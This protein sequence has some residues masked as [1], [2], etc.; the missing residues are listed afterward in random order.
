LERHPTDDTEDRRDLEECREGNEAAFE[1]LYQRYAAKLNGFAYR[2]LRRK[3]AAE[4]AVQETFIQIYRNAGKYRG[5]SSVSAWIYS[6]GLN[7]CRMRLRSE[8]R[9][10]TVPLEEA[11]DVAIPES[12]PARQKLQEVLGLLTRDE[13]ELILLRAHG[14]SY[15]EMGALLGLSADQVRG[16][17]YRTRKTLLRWM[18]EKGAGYV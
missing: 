5:D 3:D 8:R 6:I 17:L 10:P 12:S 11:A 4:D 1:R 13:R 18:D 7:A 9:R 15:E 2:I 16:R 14:H